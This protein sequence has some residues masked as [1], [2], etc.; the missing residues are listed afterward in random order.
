LVRLAEDTFRRHN[1]AQCRAVHATAEHFLSAAVGPFDCVIVDPPRQGLTPAVLA[2]ITR[3]AP[4]TLV[5]VSCDPAT[6]ARD[7][8]LIV[9]PGAYA[10]AEVALLDLYP[11]T[12]HLE[13]VVLMRRR[14]DGPV[15]T[16]SRT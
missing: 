12:H 6:L 2:G 13:S 11:N 7:V 14:G 5:Y 10:L 8:G 9:A 3:L 15:S 16:A 1:L 4:Q